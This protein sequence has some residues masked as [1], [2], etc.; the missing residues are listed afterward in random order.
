[1]SYCGH[2]NRNA[3]N[4]SLWLLNDEGLYRSVCD[5]LRRYTKE[6]TAKLLVNEYLPETTPDGVRYTVS[7]VRKALVGW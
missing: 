5:L 7:N 1:M 4:V 6:Q 2:D 3:W